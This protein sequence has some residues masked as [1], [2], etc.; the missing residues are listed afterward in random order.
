MNGWFDWRPPRGGI[1]FIAGCFIF[2][3]IVFI[4][5]GGDSWYTR[6]VIPCFLP[7]GIGLWLKHSWA[8]WLS[9][10]FFLLIGAA[11]VMAAT[12]KGVS[13]R[14]VVQ[15]LIVAGS[16]FALWEWDVYPESRQSDLDGLSFEETCEPIRI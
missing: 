9:F 14:L 13:V 3:S 4:V 5:L 2:A 16:L 12:Q 6:Y 8:R 7:I 11:L 15:A 10:G 1:A